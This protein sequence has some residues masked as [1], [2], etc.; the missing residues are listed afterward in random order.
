[1]SSLLRGLNMF[2]K[3]NNKTRMGRKYLLTW[4]GVVERGMWETVSRQTDCSCK[5]RFP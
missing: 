2:K 3:N 4:P 1:M 5:E